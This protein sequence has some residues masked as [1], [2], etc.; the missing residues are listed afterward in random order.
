MNTRL[1]GKLFFRVKYSRQLEGRVLTGWRFQD[2]KTK[3]RM[4]MDELTFF[5]GTIGEKLMQNLSRE[6]SFCK[7][8]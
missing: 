4:Q 5:I 2:I 1:H 8:L 3:Q 7:N 6:I